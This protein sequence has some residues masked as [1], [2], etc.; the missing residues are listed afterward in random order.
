MN[1]KRRKGTA[2]SHVIDGGG[3]GVCDNSGVTFPLKFVPLATATT[4]FFLTDKCRFLGEHSQKR[5][6][7]APAL[8]DA[9]GA[10]ATTDELL[11]SLTSLEI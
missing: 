10:E 7:A 5:C 9:H 1:S 3:I 8:A 2:N 6:F 4:T 11:G